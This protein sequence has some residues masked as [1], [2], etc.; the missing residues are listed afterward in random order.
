MRAGLSGMMPL[1]IQATA[2]IAA[3]ATHF[4]LIVSLL[5]IRS[6]WANTATT[7]RDRI[8]K[9]DARGGADWLRLAGENVVPWE[10][11]ILGVLTVVL[12]HWVTR[13][14]LVR[15]LTLLATMLA[16]GASFML[17]FPG[18]ASL[19]SWMMHRHLMPFMLL[20]VC[21][22]VDEIIPSIKAML[23][24]GT[25]RSENHLARPIGLV[26]VACA[27]TCVGWVA[28][29]NIRYLAGEIRWNHE[30]N[31]YSDPH[32][33]A[34]RSLDVLYWAQN[35]SRRLGN[36]L[37]PV[38]TLRVSEPPAWIHDLRMLGPGPAH[39]EV[40]WLDDVV[41]KTVRVLVD[42]SRMSEVEE[43]CSPTFFDGDAFRAASR[44]TVTGK[45]FVPAQ[46]EPAPP[47]PYAWVEFR[48]ADAVSARAVRL[49]CDG[50]EELA[51]R[52][53]EAFSE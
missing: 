5:G 27:C 36:P 43:H 4:A 32:N 18:T 22:V 48:V 16:G 25:Y 39:Y 1:L 29:R 53:I 50:I 14:R 8:V 47:N 2:P 34:A 28:V 6:A 35:D 15:P 10:V 31:R 42:E 11:V 26:C 12:S 24:R 45:T 23:C 13:A 46:G 44:D 17:A 20:V 37:M 19:H 41:L 38:S 40:W 52:Q 49:T 33:I 9:G 51:L 3:F 21:L 30:R 7:L